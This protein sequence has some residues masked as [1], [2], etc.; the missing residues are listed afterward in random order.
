MPASFAFNAV[1]AG[2]NHDEGE[3]SGGVIGVTK[4]PVIGQFPDLRI[5]QIAVDDGPQVLNLSA[6]GWF[7]RHAIFGQ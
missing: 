7:R 1:S 4:A 6:A 3:D 2:A 5:G